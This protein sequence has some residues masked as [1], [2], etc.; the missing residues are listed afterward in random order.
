M[1]T[2]PIDVNWDTEAAETQPLLPIWHAC[3]YRCTALNARQCAFVCAATASQLTSIGLP[4]WGCKEHLCNSMCVCEQSPHG[5]K[6]QGLT[7]KVCK[8]NGIFISLS[9]LP[10]ISDSWNITGWYRN[11]N[12]PTQGY[13][14][15]KAYKR[16]MGDTLEGGTNATISIRHHLQCNSVTQ[17]LVKSQPQH[18]GAPCPATVPVR[19]T[20]QSNFFSDVEPVKCAVSVSWSQSH[21][22]EGIAA[23]QQTLPC[24]TELVCLTDSASLSLLCFGMRY[25][26]IW[27]RI[28]NHSLPVL[29]YQHD[30]IQAP[31]ELSDPAFSSW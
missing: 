1:F 27:R 16:F 22:V 25:M 6:E 29:Q 8:E 30:Q 17:S 3:G 12:T 20:Q 23:R 14:S 4:A 26:L 10:W 21:G 11:T 2:C 28:T 7:L 13:A 19:Q 24:D 9:S 18:Y 31:R 5:C 15:H